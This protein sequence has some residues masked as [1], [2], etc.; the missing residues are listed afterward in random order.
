MVLVRKFQK[1]KRVQEHEL[2]LELREDHFSERF[3]LKEVHDLVDFGEICEG[4]DDQLST[5]Q[6]HKNAF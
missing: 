6:D 5:V 3:N 4:L 1:L 2:I